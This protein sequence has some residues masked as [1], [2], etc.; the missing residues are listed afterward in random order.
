M[1][2]TNILLFAVITASNMLYRDAELRVIRVFEMRMMLEAVV[3]R[4]S[5]LS[6]NTLKNPTSTYVGL[7]PLPAG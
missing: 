5:V 7:T 1:T 3:R 6:F 2:A 4:Y